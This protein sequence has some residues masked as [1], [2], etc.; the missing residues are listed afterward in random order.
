MTFSWLKQ[1][2]IDSPLTN[3]EIA[4]V[5]TGD[6][7]GKRARIAKLVENEALK[8]AKVIF[9]FSIIYRINH[10]Q[11]FF[12]HCKQL[13]YQQCRFYLRAISSE[14][15]NSNIADIVLFPMVI[16]RNLYKKKNDSNAYFWGK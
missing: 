14:I 7:L 12:V 15:V 13:D 3:F 10:A 11:S 9:D 4:T 8:H 6:Q 2:A 1:L 5:L 16:F